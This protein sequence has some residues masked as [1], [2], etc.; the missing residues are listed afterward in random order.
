MARKKIL[1]L[2]LLLIIFSAGCTSAAT[3]TASPVPTQTPTPIS[4]TATPLPPTLPP[5]TAVAT[6][7]PV[8]PTVMPTSTLPPIVTVN[9]GQNSVQV[10]T[11]P[12][13]TSAKLGYLN[14]G[15]QVAAFGI[16]PAQDWIEIGFSLGIGNKGWVAASQVNLS[17]N[18]LPVVIPTGGPTPLPSATATNQAPARPEDITSIRSFL[19]QQ[20][21]PY[22]FLG[23]LPYPNNHRRTVDQYQV[24]NTLYSVDLQSNLL[25]QIDATRNIHNSSVT[26]QYS[27][28]QLQQ[29]AIILIHQQAPGVDLSKLTPKPGSKPNNYFFRWEEPN[30][31]GFIQVGIT[32]YGELLTYDNALTD[33][34]S[35]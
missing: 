24:Y 11:W 1:T 27:P 4:N 13:A 31:S 3:P 19:R 18:T 7:T 12:D 22:T 6:S 5:P 20:T 9:S 10:Y 28:D 29:M 26:K 30:S 15:D 17:A 21:F 23:Q 35:G 14:P 34:T 2:M 8:T 16:S 32:I 33:P 25:I